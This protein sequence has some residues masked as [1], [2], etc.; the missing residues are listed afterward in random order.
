MCVWG[1]GRPTSN[2]IMSTR[3]LP[4]DGSPL[5]SPTSDP[6]T[7]SLNLESPIAVHAHLCWGIHSINA[8]NKNVQHRQ[9]PNVISYSK[10]YVVVLE[11]SWVEHDGSCLCTIVLC[12]A[13]P[14]T[15]TKDLN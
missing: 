11:S 10:K 1:G 14:D 15:D 8:F 7:S 3:K 4:A 9:S 5:P 13:L 2:L 12:D 6:H